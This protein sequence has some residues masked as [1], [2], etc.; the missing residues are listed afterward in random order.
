MVF[1]Q[2]DKVAASSVTVQIHFQVDKSPHLVKTGCFN[3]TCDAYQ[4][5][6]MENRERENRI[7]FSTIVFFAGEINLTDILEQFFSI[8][9]GD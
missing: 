7:P 6:W 3:G 9:Q 8:F 5:N 2:S 4:I 1:L